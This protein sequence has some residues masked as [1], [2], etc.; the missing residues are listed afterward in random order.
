MNYFD[1]HTACGCWT[2]TPPS[3]V[4]VSTGPVSVQG[5]ALRSRRSVG[6]RG[7]SKWEESEWRGDPLPSWSTSAVCWQRTPPGPWSPGDW[8]RGRARSRSS[9]AQRTRGKDLGHH[10]VIQTSVVALAQFQY[11]K[12]KK[13]NWPDSFYF[14]YTRCCSHESIFSVQLNI[15]TV[16]LQK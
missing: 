1:N 10:E 3:T 14:T 9:P 7:L 6:S 12:Q 2:T 15:I 5:K 11:E 4:V 16:I 8:S 13:E